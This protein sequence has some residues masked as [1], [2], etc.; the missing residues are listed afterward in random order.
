MAAGVALCAD[1]ASHGI[2]PDAVRAR[3]EAQGVPAA[4]FPGQCGRIPSAWSTEW[5][6]TVVATCPGGPSGEEVRSR[7]R[8]TGADPA[9]G[10]TSVDIV[11]ASAHGPPDRRIDR[12]ALVLAARVAGVWAAAPSPPEAFRMALQTGKLSRRSWDAAGRR[13]AGF[14][15]MPVPSMRSI[16]RERCRKSVSRRASGVA[17]A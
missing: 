5:D 8:R 17:P 7:A 13:R 3:L 4:V 10:A 15:S 16:A 1:L 14:A 11:S 2:E 6:R 12:A 9:V